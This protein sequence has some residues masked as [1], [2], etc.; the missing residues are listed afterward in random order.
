MCCLVNYVLFLCVDLCKKNFKF[1][2]GCK[3]NND[4]HKTAEILL[5]SN[6]YG[7]YIIAIDLTTLMPSIPA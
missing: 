1:I 3:A 2:N 5:I 6:I 4:A 7:A